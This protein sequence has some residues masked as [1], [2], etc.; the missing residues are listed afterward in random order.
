M[1]LI[2]SSRHPR[3]STYSAETGEVLYKIDKPY[4]L[5]PT[6]ATIRK[7][8]GTVNGV[9]NGDS[10]Q[11]KVKA[12]PLVHSSDSDGEKGDLI[13]DDSRWH[14]SPDGEARPS[15]SEV[16]VFEGHFAF[17]AQVEFHKVQSTRFRYNGLDVPV[18]EYFRK[19]GWS[20]YGR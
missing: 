1:Q 3:N 4:K 7:A 6:V 2:L 18:S 16:P 17:Y 8:V 19:E 9:W 5:S 13:H 10:E 11:F 14:N 12:N 15:G 20:C